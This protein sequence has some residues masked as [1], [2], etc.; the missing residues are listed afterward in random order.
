MFADLFRPKSIVGALPVTLT[1]GTTADATQVMQDLNWLVNQVNANAAPLSTTALVNANNN[2]S[3]VQSGVAATSPANFPIA[4]Q[5]Q[6][7][8]FNTLSSTLG[9]N[10]ITAR[11]SA[12]PLTAYATGQVFTFVPSQTNT[13][14][15]SLTV[16]A[17]GSSIIFTMGSTLRGGE[18]RAGVP[19]LVFRDGSKLNL[20]NS[21]QA[22][23]PTYTQFLG[24]D[25]ALN[26][27][28]TQFT[29]PIVNQGTVGIWLVTTNLV[30]IDTAG[31]A[32]FV[33]A[34]TDGGTVFASGVTQSR[35]ANAPVSASITAICADP[36][37]GLR[38][39]GQDLTSTSGAMLFNRSGTLR[40]CSITAVRIA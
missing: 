29:G 10:T 2:F 22:K 31:A 33:Y 7:Q 26:N 20:E 40:D 1:N 9:T 11:V 8:S 36:V 34:I 24:A 27:T 21:A 12:L 16:D 23:L 4:S 17:A 13:G 25:V 35:T 18:L 32:E 19:A 30:F 37:A 3:V 28:V 14:P 15:A 38:A 39:I 5:V 6:N